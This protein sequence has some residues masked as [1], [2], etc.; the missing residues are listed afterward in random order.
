MEFD[1]DVCDVELVAL[2]KIFSGYDV[3]FGCSR[4]EGGFRVGCAGMVEV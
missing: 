1:I 3:E 2:F 4:W